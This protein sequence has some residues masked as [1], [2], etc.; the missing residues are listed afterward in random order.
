MR[1]K[2]L[3]LFK[4]DQSRGIF[5]RAEDLEALQYKEF[6]WKDFIRNIMIAHISDNGVAIRSER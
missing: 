4:W 6:I 3:R 5:Y 2:T 1:L